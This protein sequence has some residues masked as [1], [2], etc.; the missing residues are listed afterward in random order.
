MRLIPMCCTAPL[1]SNNTSASHPVVLTC[2]LIA[3]NRL[4]FVLSQSQSGCQKY[5]LQHQMCIYP[6]LKVVPNIFARNYC[7]SINCEKCKCTAVV[8]IIHPLFLM[9]H[10]W[11]VI[12][13]LLFSRNQWVWGCCRQGMQDRTYWAADYQTHLAW[14]FSWDLYN[15]TRL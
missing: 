11:P 14:V 10:L 12:Q 13:N 1:L 2:S 8:E 4:Y 3:T 15:I 5:S 9:Q 6:Q 7:L